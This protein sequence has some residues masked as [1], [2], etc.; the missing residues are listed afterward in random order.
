MTLA[1][2]LVA[3]VSR[4][5]P[6]GRKLRAEKKLPWKPRVSQGYRPI[7]NA[8]VIY[9]PFYLRSW[10]GHWFIDRFRVYMRTINFCPCGT[11]SGVGVSERSDFFT[12]IASIFYTRFCWLSTFRMNAF[13]FFSDRLLRIQQKRANGV[14]DWPTYRSVSFIKSDFFFHNSRS[15]KINPDRRL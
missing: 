6:N 9:R 12:V 10:C 1:L 5:V 4:S 14:S 13:L 3:R 7:G 8:P 11:P 15:E 2:R